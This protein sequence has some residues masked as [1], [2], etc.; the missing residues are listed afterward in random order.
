MRQGGQGGIDFPYCPQLHKQ[1]QTLI[2]ELLICLFS[3]IGAGAAISEGKKMRA[4]TATR[5]V[6]NISTTMNGAM[7]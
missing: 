3:S 1:L 6:R 5:A 2:S 7:Y 4:L